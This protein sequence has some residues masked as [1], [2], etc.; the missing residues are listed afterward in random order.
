MTQEL[1]QDDELLALSG[2]Q[3]LAFCERQWGLL[4]LEQQWTE[5]LFTAEGR[6]LHHRVDDPF[7]VE[8][9]GELMVSRS[10][11]IHSYQLGLYGVIDIIEWHQLL[12]EQPVK[13]VKLPDKTGYWIPYPVEYKRG[14]QKPDDRDEVQICGQ[15][16][17][18][19][20]MLKIQIASGSLYYGLQRHRFPVTFSQELRSRVISLA[21]KM[22]E[23][24]D[25]E[26]TPQAKYTKACE[27][28][29]MKE[30]CLPKLSRK[31]KT[32]SDYIQDL[33]DNQ[34]KLEQ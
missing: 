5:N 33:L 3:H 24:Y 7:I 22:H 13:A 6:Q 15:A 14:K 25:A 2:L 12:Q 27:L 21:K 34:S 30:V 10:V 1:Y 18:L 20:E 19:E 17:C 28:C 4:V 16:I 11:P 26:V 8:S 32:A 23:L 31:K 29:S 9:R